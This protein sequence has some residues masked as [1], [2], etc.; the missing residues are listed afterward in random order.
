MEKLE[1]Y[2]IISPIGIKNAERKIE[3]D[4]LQGLNANRI[5]VNLSSFPYNSKFWHYVKLGKKIRRPNRNLLINN[6]F[7]IFQKGSKYK[8]L[9]GFIKDKIQNHPSCQIEIYYQNLQCPLT[10]TVFFNFSSLFSKKE[11]SFSIIEEGVGNYYE[12]FQYFPK[13]R[14][15]L[16]L[17]KVLY[18]IYGLRVKIPVSQICYFSPFVKNA[19]LRMPG[20]SPRPEISKLLEF[21]KVEYQPEKNTVLMLGQESNSMSHGIEFYLSEQVKLINDV[22]SILPHSKLIYKPHWD[23]DLNIENMFNLTTYQNLIVLRNDSSIEE[24]IHTI[25]PK[26][27]VS[28]TFND[29]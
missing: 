24:I 28:F 14:R 22:N 8:K 7:I 9:L 1:V 10:N 19:Y 29:Y 12:Y 2:I 3:C 5:L 16:Y 21:P 17:K 11:V 20:F 25:R 15:K 23:L 27:V 4:I 26:V 6:L 18:F 13:E